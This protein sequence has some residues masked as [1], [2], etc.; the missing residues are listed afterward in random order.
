MAK[1][2]LGE[3]ELL[4]LLAALRLG[5]EDAYALAIAEDI[6]SQT[7]RRASRAAVYVTLQRLEDKGLVRTQLGA[8]RP[9][10]GGKARRHVKVQ[11]RGVRAVRQSRDA[12]ERMWVGL[13]LN[14]DGSR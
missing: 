12:L 3:F 1:D 14:A 13:E 4:V 2:S 9:E 7:G 10:R 8:P 11:S 6:A 5:E